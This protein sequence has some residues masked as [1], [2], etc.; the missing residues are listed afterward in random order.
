MAIKQ[1]LDLDSGG[2]RSPFSG[3]RCPR[4][5]TTD[6]MPWTRGTRGVWLQCHRCNKL[7]EQQIVSQSDSVV[8]AAPNDVHDTHRLS[9][10]AEPTLDPSYA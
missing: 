5:Q 1:I 2:N 4:C 6:P 7:W 8:E 3:M 10:I 9:E